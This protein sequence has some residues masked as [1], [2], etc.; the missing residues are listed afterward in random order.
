MNIGEDE[1]IIYIARVRY[2]EDEPIVSVINHKPYKICSDL[3]NEDLK[4]RSLYRILAE[5]YGLNA[6]KV[7]VT[8]EPVVASEYETELLH[9]EEG[10]PVHL[11]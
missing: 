3:I 1:K 5:K 6:Y 11:M 10:A 8:L 7:K 9:I 4:N 2:I